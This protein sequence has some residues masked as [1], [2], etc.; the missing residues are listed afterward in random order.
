[1][2]ALKIVISLGKKSLIN[3]WYRLWLLSESKME[4]EGL[5]VKMTFEIYWEQSV[6]V[7]FSV[8]LPSGKVKQ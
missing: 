4:M 1:M 7:A 6:T 8:T 5:E 3:V 2:V